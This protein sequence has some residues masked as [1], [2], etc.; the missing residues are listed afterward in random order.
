MSGLT[1]LFFIFWLMCDAILCAWDDS[2]TWRMH[3]SVASSVTLFT[4][5]NSVHPCIFLHVIMIST[6]KKDRQFIYIY[7]LWCESGE[8]SY[9]F[10][11][12][13]MVVI[14]AHFSCKY[15][16]LIIYLTSQFCQQYSSVNSIQ[17]AI[18]FSFTLQ[19]V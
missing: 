17:S 6:H 18:Q 15:A 2:S 5:K 19:V 3:Y 12:I 1:I 7:T 10:H 8:Y 13:S 11:S 4:F 9:W 16:E 14:K